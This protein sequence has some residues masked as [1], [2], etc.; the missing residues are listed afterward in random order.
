MEFLGEDMGRCAK[1]RVTEKEV[2][3]SKVAPQR[4]GNVDVAIVGKAKIVVANDRL[5]ISD[6]GL[7]NAIRDAWVLVVNGDADEALVAA[8]HPYVTIVNGLAASDER[9]AEMCAAHSRG[10]NVEDAEGAHTQKKVLCVSK[11]DCI[12]VLFGESREN[13]VGLLS[14]ECK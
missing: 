12:E 5:A 6:E 9:L 10:W 2:V 7:V 8:A 4:V 1:M 13:P 14:V 11:D 3:F